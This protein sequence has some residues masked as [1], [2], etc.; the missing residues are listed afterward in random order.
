[1]KKYTFLY[2]LIILFTMAGCRFNKYSEGVINDTKEIFKKKKEY[3]YLLDFSGQVVDKKV[4]NECKIN[5]YT[6][7]VYLKRINNKPSFSDKQYP[8]YYMFTSDSTL[9]LSVNEDLFEKVEESGMIEKQNKSFALRINQIDI[10]YL[11]EEESKW[12]P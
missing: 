10:K 11:S 8:P 5:K 1:M 2:G 4:C 9:N 3:I 7:T 6:I 12:L